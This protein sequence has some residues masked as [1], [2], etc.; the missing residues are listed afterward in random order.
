MHPAT[1]AG[2][3]IPAMPQCPLLE[4]QLERL[5]RAVQKLSARAAPGLGGWRK[6]LVL[7]LVRDRRCV[8]GIAFLVRHIL[9]GTIADPVLREALLGS[10]LIALLKQV[11]S[12]AVRP[13][14][15]GDLFVKLAANY[16]FDLVQG[17]IARTFHPIQL[18][19]FT[20]GGVEKA[21]L[22]AQQLLDSDMHSVM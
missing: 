4:I 21:V 11:G 10:R 1:Y 7:P 8:H 19:L 15:I 22:A 12:D 14:A 5:D 20:R 3:V 6:A 17:H 18:G 2:R 13:I 16:A 9:N